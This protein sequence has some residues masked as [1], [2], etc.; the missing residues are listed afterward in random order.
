MWNERLK[1]ISKREEYQLLY[2]NPIEKNKKWVVEGDGNG[3]G[4]HVI[5]C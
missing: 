2:Q 5:T 1:G 4:S 3:W